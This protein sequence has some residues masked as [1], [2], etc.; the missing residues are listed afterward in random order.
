MADQYAKD[1]ATGRAPREELL[2]GYAEETSLARVTRVAT[3]TGSKATTD[4]ITE[5]ATRP[6]LQT[7]S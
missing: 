3:E 4:Q 2:E 7:S 1:A 5:H 6:T